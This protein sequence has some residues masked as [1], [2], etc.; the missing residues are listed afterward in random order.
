MDNRVRIIIEKDGKQIESF[1]T[2]C[3]IVSGADLIDESCTH[4]LA[5][6]LNTNEMKLAKVVKGIIRCLVE[7]IGAKRLLRL[8]MRVAFLRTKREERRSLL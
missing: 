4:A 3:F 5:G 7:T 6:L 8:V 2:N 1:F